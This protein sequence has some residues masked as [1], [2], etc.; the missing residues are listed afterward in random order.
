MN[1]PFF[2]DGKTFDLS[3]LFAG[4]I[5]AILSRPWKNRVKGR[6]LYDYLYYIGEGVSINLK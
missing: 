6:D 1:D 3:S 2:E 5:S 4:K